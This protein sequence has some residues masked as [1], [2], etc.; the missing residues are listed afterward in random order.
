MT[1]QFIAP[2]PRKKISRREAAR[3]FLLHNGICCNCGRQIRGN[4][5]FIEH[6]EAL[7]L[8]G[9]DDDANRRPAHVKCKAEKDAADA[10]TRAERDRHITSSYRPEGERRSTWAKRPRR[11]APPQKTATGRINKF[12]PID[13]VYE[14]EGDWS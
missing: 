13:G 6:V 8:G 1:V 14:I 3:L 12:S 7:V 4:D 11:K 2:T 10:K 5:W 9:A